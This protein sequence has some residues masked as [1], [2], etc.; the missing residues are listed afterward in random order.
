ML[1]STEFLVYPKEMHIA[2][3]NLR[4]WMKLRDTTFLV[5]ITFEQDELSWNN[6][7]HLL[8]QAPSCQVRKTEQ[9]KLF[10]LIDV[11]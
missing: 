3:S 6:W 2:H 11:T 9:E 1:E 4:N 10:E 8:N 5:V 7:L